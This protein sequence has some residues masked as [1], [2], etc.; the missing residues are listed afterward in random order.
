M[1]ELGLIVRSAGLTVPSCKGRVPM[2]SELDGRGAVVIWASVF[3]VPK[4]SR[5]SKSRLFIHALNTGFE[6]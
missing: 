6:W 5:G 3:S 2:S 1:P 4:L